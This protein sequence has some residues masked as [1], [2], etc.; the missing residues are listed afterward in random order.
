VVFGP[1]VQVVIHS[2]FLIDYKQPN[3][4]FSFQKLCSSYSKPIGLVLE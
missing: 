2:V 3:E 1:M 4:I